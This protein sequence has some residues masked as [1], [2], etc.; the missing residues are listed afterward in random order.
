MTHSKRN[1]T[2]RIGSSINYGTDNIRLLTNGRDMKT[3]SMLRQTSRLNL[4]QIDDSGEQN[5]FVMT[6]IDEDEIKLPKIGSNYN[7][8]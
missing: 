2:L 3:N 1:G 4:S 8:T 6:E 5:T 7:G